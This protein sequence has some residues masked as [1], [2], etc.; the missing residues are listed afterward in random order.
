MTDGGS[1]YPIEYGVTDT[2]P[3]LATP[4]VGAPDG[5]SPTARPFPDPA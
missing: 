4:P 2:Q 3:V 5:C 1:Y